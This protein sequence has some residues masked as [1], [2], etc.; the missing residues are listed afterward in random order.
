[1]THS[2]RH[3]DGIR[4]D[5]GYLLR[6]LERGKDL[7][8]TLTDLAEAAQS[9]RGN[10][11]HRPGR[12]PAPSHRARAGASPPLGQHHAR[13]RGNTGPLR[14]LTRAPERL[15]IESGRPPTTPGGSRHRA[16][17][18]EGNRSRTSA[19]EGR[20]HRP[21]GASRHRAESTGTLARV[22]GPGTA[23]A[24]VGAVS[25]W[26]A[27][28]R[29]P[30]CRR[31]VRG[32][33]A[34]RGSSL[35]AGGFL[36]AVRVEQ[37]PPAVRHEDRVVDR[38]YAVG[39]GQWFFFPAIEPA[40]AFGRAAQMSTECQGYGVYEAAVE[41]LYCRSHG[42]DERVLLIS[43]PGLHRNRDAEI[44][45]LKRFVQAVKENPHRPHWRSPTGYLTEL[46]QGRPAQ[47]HRRSLPL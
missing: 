30:L 42:C 37:L 19:S 18:A 16:E 41:L 47:S 9:G 28:G 11:R 23:V 7:A 34:R 3:D 38:G 32:H 15:A 26:G 10:G 1:M 17:E 36:A 46:V 40:I 20:H 2:A 22:G 44:D 45:V 31:Y 39:F 33:N 6:A 25:R 43:G 21:T 35:R 8:A 29:A 27:V 14:E 13:G 12:L 5:L 4:T 24:R